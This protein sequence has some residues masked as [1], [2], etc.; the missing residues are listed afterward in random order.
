MLIKT[1]I[2]YS[3]LSCL[4]KNFNSFSTENSLKIGNIFVKSTNKNIFCTLLDFKDKKVKT[5]CSL[6]VPEYKNEFNERVSLF[7]RGVLLG[8]L[9][10]DKIIELGYTEVYIYLDYGINKARKGVVKGIGE[11]KIKIS[12]IRLIKGYPHNG[13]RPAKLR[14]KKVRTKHKA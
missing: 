13:C 9:F 4:K 12:F 5:S 8:Q 1:S 6:R 3:K 14:R 10:G 2:G 11:K 7:K